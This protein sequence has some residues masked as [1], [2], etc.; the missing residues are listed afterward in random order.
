MEINIR[1]NWIIYPGD[2]GTKTGS[3]DTVKW[4]PTASSIVVGIALTNPIFKI[5]SQNQ[6]CPP[7]YACIQIYDIP[8]DIIQEYN[9]LKYV[10]DG[11]IYSEIRKGVYGISQT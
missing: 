3:L 5:L 9:L 6:Y 10:H 11:W 1:G 8:K 4:F 2:I 7:K